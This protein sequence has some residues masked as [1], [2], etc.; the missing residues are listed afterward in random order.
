[1]EGNAGLP[2]AAEKQGFFDFYLAPTILNN[3]K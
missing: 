3:G 1:M 2:P